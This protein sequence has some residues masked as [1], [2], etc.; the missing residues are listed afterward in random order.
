VCGGV[1]HSRDA[2][3]RRECGACGTSHFPR[4]DP[5]VIV[6]VHDGERCLL[7]RQSQW[8]AGMHSVLAGFVEPGESLEAC[9]AREVAEES[10]I[11]VDGVTYHSSQPWPFPQSLMIGFTARAVTTAILAD[12]D[13]LEHV[14][15]YSRAF[16]KALPPDGPFRLPRPDS[17]ARRLL[18]EWLGEG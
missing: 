14:G 13:E 5:A 16:L 6:L 12:D 10:G 3:H 18:D 1:T 15:W 4:T 11:L 7:G 9:V 8:P 2:G 17:I